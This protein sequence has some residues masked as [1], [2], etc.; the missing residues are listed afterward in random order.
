M[1]PTL[2]AWIDGIGL[3]AP[4]LDDWASG[5]KTLAA[6][7][8]LSRPLA[9]PPALALPPAERRRVGLSVKVA[10][11]V[12]QQA[13]A[14]AGA[15][16]RDLATVFASSGADGDN[17]DAICQVLASD[18]R[19][20]SPTRFHNS[21]HNAPAGYWGIAS[22]SM[23]PANVV[24]AYD[25]SF[26]AGLLEAMTLINHAA[27]VLLVAYEAP[28]P[29]PLQAK[30]PHPSAFGVAL[31]LMS[32]AGP[33]SLAKISLELDHAVAD[34]LD[35]ATL[36]ALRSQIPSARALPLLQTLVSG[37]GSVVLEYLPPLA[38]RVKVEPCR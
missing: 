2:T 25:A 8:Y 5:Q 6:G 30:R 10:L 15:D 3:L 28:Y 11:A 27:G 32:H 19:H 22:A 1:K 35:N 20:I 31:T 24:C 36:E 37:G 38:L 17:C 14:S 9:V 34:T 7:D 16:A 4:G 29:E 13:V 12:A 23:Q 33:H 21:V 18:D 26:G